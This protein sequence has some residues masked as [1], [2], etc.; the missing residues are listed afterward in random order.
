MVKN[1]NSLRNEAFEKSFNVLDRLLGDIGAG[2][3]VCNL[4]DK[5]TIFENKL[6]QESQEIHRAVEFGLEEFYANDFEEESIKREYFDTRSGLWFE[7]VV[8]LTTW[9]DGTE[10]VACTV[11]DITLRKK[12]QQKI[13]YQTYNDFLTGLYNRKKCEIDLRKQIRH[14]EETGKKAAFLFIDLDDFKDINDGLG[15]QY[16]DL[17]LQQVAAGLQSVGGL[18]GHCYRMGGDEFGVIVTDDTY[19][20]LSSKIQTISVL[21]NNPWY[22]M[23]TEY[24]CTM[25]MGVIEFPF[26]GNTA[27]DIIKKADIAMYEA[28]WGGKNKI[29]FYQ[30]GKDYDSTK[31][32]DIE[33]NLRW[34]VADK[35]NEFIV[36]YQ[37]IVD[38]KTN[39]CIACEALIRW[40]S[41]GLGFVCPGEFIPLAEYMGLIVSIGNYVLEEVC[42]QCKYWNEHGY[43]DLKVDVNLSVVQLMQK[44]AVSSIQRVFESTGVNPANICLEVTET[45]AINDMERVTKIIANLKALGPNVAL[46]DFGTGYSSLNYIK[47]LPLDVVKVDKAFIDDILEDDYAQAFIKLIVELSKTLN[48]R[49]CVEGVETKEQ[50]ELLSQL[51]VDLIQGFYFGRPVPPDEFARR[52]L[53]EL[54]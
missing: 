24:F 53:T 50:Y 35:C 1:L 48:L 2:I 7:Y 54:E 45:L 3:L 11:T 40:N 5:R 37:P 19:D 8:S 6:C 22:L 10:A 34:A 25:S 32:L 49:I 43:P 29:S 14:C 16:G 30:Q 13:A 51:G 21:F 4:K 44:D 12:N 20:E 36:Y 23:E 47:K 9:I 33:N 46:D 41:S 18:K 38:V 28:K 26:E 27:N 17:L 31:R 15:H 52:N 42:K 39:K